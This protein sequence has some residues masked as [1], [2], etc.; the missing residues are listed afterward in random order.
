MHAHIVDWAHRRYGLTSASASASGNAN[1]T[2]AWT[3][4]VDSAYAQ[5]VDGKEEEVT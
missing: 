4:L 5:V 2:A 1:V 3:L